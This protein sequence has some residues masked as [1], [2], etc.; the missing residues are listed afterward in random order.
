MSDTVDNVLDAVNE[1]EPADVVVVEETTEASEEEAPVAS[2]A[3]EAPEEESVAS[4]AVEAVEAPEEE[5]VASEAAEAVEAVEAPEEESVEDEEPNPPSEAVEQVVSDIRDILSEDP[6]AT[7]ESSVSGLTDDLKQRIAELDYL[8]EL[9]ENLSNGN[10]ESRNDIVKMWDN[11]SIIIS[12]DVDYQIILK[13]LENLPN[14]I[15]KTL[16]NKEV[17]RSEL[18][19]NINNIQEKIEILEKLI[20]IMHISIRRVDIYLDNF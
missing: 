13:N 9:Y 2:E 10:I 12:S 3:V 1:S 15:G 4:E 17:N 19:I 20:N 8:R 7:E 5:S 6:V 14:I 11:K 18:F 16:R